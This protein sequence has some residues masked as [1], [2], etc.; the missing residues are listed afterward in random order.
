M[1]KLIQLLA[2]GLFALVLAGPTFAQ[3]GEAAAEEPAS[4]EDQAAAQ[5]D[6]ASEQAGKLIDM[7]N[8]FLS[9]TL[10][11]PEAVA[12]IIAKIAIFLAILL[13]AKILAGVAS[14]LVR[15]A[16]NRSKLNATNLL[17]DFAAGTAG[18]IV[19][20]LGF[21]IA[22]TAL[23]VNI[24]PF[25][26]AFGVLGFVIGFALQDTL[27]NFAAGVMILLY[28]PYDVGDVV[29]AGGVTGKVTDMN[30]V[31]TLFKTPDNQNIIV[32]NGQIW[33]GTITNI[34]A[35]DTRRV[36][37]TAGIGYGDDIEKAEKVLMDIVTSHPLV[38]SDPAP[39]IKLHEL[40]DSSVNFV[41]RPWSKTSDYWDVYWDLTREIKLRFD[42]ESISIP[43]PQT[44]VHL[45]KVE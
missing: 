40:A 39:V 44:D 19:F 43:F 31:S 13:I 8:G 34:T 12:G 41:V 27:G 32:P 6:A 36:D 38:L 22:L 3:E 45:H 35:N 37:L 20:F 14:S 4:A 5:L 18:K 10:G 11:V 9:E 1:H 23:G 7:V 29:N 16:L 2:A 15:G 21:L 42:K 33:G 24:G 25:L 26:A 30:L 28:K 17:K